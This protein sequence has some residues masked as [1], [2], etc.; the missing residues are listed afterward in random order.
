MFTKLQVEVAVKA[1]EKI[2]TEFEIA[3]KTEIY[4]IPIFV[5]AVSVEEY[6]NI[7]EESLRLHGRS[8]L[9]PSV[10]GKTYNS[11]TV[12]WGEST[13]SDAVLPKLPRI[14]N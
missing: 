5:N 3:S 14:A 6:D 11:S 8:V 10:K 13:S 2:E 7:N 12:R 1:P 9:K 4:R